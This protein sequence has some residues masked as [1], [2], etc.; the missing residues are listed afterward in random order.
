MGDIFDIETVYRQE[1]ERWF[2]EE[3]PRKSLRD[4]LTESVPYWIVLV[5][6]VLYGLSA[7][8]KAGVFNKLTPGWG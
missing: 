4:L 1:K 2:R 6:L 7:P 5:A 8:H 3:A